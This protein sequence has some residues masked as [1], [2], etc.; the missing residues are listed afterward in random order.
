MSNEQKK[1]TTLEEVIARFEQL[2]GLSVRSITRKFAGPYSKNAEAILLTPTDM[3][4]ARVTFFE[5]RNGE[6]YFGGVSGTFP[7]DWNVLCE[8]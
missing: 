1:A 5:N 2:T 7:D 4:L 3:V 8:L 6:W